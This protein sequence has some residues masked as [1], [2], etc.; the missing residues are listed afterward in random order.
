MKILVPALSFVLSYHNSTKKVRQ[1]G[2]QETDIVS[3]SKPI[4][5]FSYQLK[6]EN[7]NF[8][9]SHKNPKKE[10]IH[11]LLPGFDNEIIGTFIPQTKQTKESNNFI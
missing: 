8:A 10:L 5:K 6:N 4:T 1:V 7:E 11:N 9:V 3:M 2:F